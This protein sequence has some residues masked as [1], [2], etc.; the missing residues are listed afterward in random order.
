M[1]YS[2]GKVA[3]A[4]EQSCNYAAALSTPAAGC[5]DSPVARHA[6]TPP[7][8]KQSLLVHMLNFPTEFSRSC[9]T[10]ASLEQ[11][12]C[13]HRWPKTA[14]L[15]HCQPDSHTRDSK[16]ARGLPG[17]QQ[18]HSA[19]AHLLKTSLA[20]RHTCRPILGRNQKPRGEADALLIISCCMLDVHD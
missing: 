19:E 16:Q 3:T 1:H 14:G 15:Y 18:M 2:S 7:A 10:G 5:R 12:S 4:F 11:F 9:Q 20:E 6:W 17:V 13:L 8:M